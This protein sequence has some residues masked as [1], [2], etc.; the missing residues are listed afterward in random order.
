MEFCAYVIL[1]GLKVFHSRYVWSLC[2]AAVTADSSAVPDAPIGNFTTTDTTDA[3]TSMVTT[4]GVSSNYPPCFP[5]WWQGISF[6]TQNLL[7]FIRYGDGITNIHTVQLF[8]NT[9]W[10]FFLL[11]RY[12]GPLG[13][14]TGNF[15]ILFVLQNAFSAWIP[16][17]QR[18]HC[19]FCLLFLDTRTRFHCVS[20][21]VV[22]WCSSLAEQKRKS[23]ESLM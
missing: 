15:I 19:R 10:L 8:Y 7:I 17:A 9:Q 6:F 12:R 4:D 3:T 14:L 23:G 16:H 21:S 20:F 22:P 1:H 18:R 2:A 11:R 13:K 5:C